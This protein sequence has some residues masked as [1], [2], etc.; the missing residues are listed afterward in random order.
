VDR[1][2]W[3]ITFVLL[4]TSA[5][6]AQTPASLPKQVFYPGLTYDSHRHVTVLFDGLGENRTYPGTWEWNGSSWTAKSGDQPPDRSGHGIVYDTTRQ[7]IVVFGGFAPNDQLLGD[8]WE[9]D[10]S[11]WRRAASTGPP[12]RGAMGMAFDSRRSR[13]VMFGGSSGPGRPVFQ[14]TWEWDGVSWTT[15][16]AS[17]PSGRSFHK[18]AFDV[19]RGRVVSFGGRGGGDDTW[20][21]DGREWTKVADAGPPPRDHHAMAYDTR[22]S[23]VLMFGG[24]QNLPDGGYPPKPVL[25]RDLWSWDGS[26]WLELSR[27]GPPSGGGLPGLTYDEF[28][29]RLVLFGGGDLEGTWEWDGGRWERKN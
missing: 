8:T 25:L 23:R 16:A 20:T 14:D 7:R 11:V 22:R 12:P 27:E 5:L 21:W 24:S 3:H 28:R 4:C 17:G 26:K 13:T 18:M 19:A 10:G 1:S 15:V 9:Y 6:Y 29:D 2:A